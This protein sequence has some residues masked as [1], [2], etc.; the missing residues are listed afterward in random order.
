M[1]ASKGVVNLTK[2]LLTR[3]RS[4]SMELSSEV[5]RGDDISGRSGGRLGFT[6]TLL[7]RH[8][9][10]K[11]MELSSEVK[12]GDDISGRSGGRRGYSS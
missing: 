8:L 4:K 3:H 6:K 9:F 10:F 12:K 2:T 7:A 11:S 1:T 5:K